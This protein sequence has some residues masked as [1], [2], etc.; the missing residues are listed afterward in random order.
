MTSALLVVVMTGQ[1][2]KLSFL[3]K[4]SKT[5]FLTTATTRTTIAIT[6]SSFLEYPG[7]ANK[8]FDNHIF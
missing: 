2:L 4:R 5:F 6:I 3:T 1:N 7:W 8:I